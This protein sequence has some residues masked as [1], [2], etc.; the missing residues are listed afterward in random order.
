VFGNNFNGAQ[1][2]AFSKAAL[3]AGAATVNVVQFEN[4]VLSDG[5]PGFTVWPGAGPPTTATPPAD[6]GTEYFLAPRRP[7]RPST[8][9]ALDNRIGL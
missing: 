3:A 1:V 9:R 8:S 5:T 4:L 2:Y 7:R 6:H